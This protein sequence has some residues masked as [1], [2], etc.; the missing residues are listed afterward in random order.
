M[1]PCCH[2]ALCATLAV[3]AIG[4]ALA[5]AP[6][7]RWIVGP[8]I[9][10]PGP[11]GSF[12]SVAVKDPSI[13][14]YDGRWHLFYTARDP[15]N[16]T[17]GYASAESL[18][19]VGQAKRYPLRQLRS[20]NSPY[21]AAPQ[22][23]YFRPQRKW[24]LV[25]QTTGANYQPVYSTS[26]DVSQPASWT[27][28][29]PLLPK[30]DD[31][32][33]I[34]FW[35]I[36]DEK[37]AYLFF[38]RNHRDV[39]VMSTRLADFPQGFGDAKTVLSPVHEAVHVYALPGA[40]PGYVMLFEQQEGDLRHFGLASA[41]ALGGPW[42]VTNPRF[43]SPEQLEYRGGKGQG[44][45]PQRHWTDEVSHGEFLRAGYDERLIIPADNWEFLIQGLPRER[46]QGAYPLLPWSVGIIRSEAPHTLE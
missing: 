15:E 25:F 38:T 43:A 36:C 1:L 30:T 39:V 6:P 46:H 34:D 4:V 28:P 17:L 22:V 27:P 21:A 24:Y 35:I 7:L 32:K 18:E 14:R 26:S 29:L 9:L 16:Y 19:T 5:I 31:A 42:T 45:K 33:W 11:E 3:L 10:E 23:F 44:S 37:K 40:K 20:G 12:D 2:K 41:P 13:V 8:V